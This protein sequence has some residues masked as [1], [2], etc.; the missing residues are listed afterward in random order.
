MDFDMMLVKPLTNLTNKIGLQRRKFEQNQS[1][2]NAILI[3]EPNND[4]ILS[5]IHTF[6]TQAIP[7]SEE[8]GIN[9]PGL[10]TG[11]I[12]KHYRG[13]E[14]NIPNP[15]YTPL[16]STGV[17]LPCPVQVMPRP[18]FYPIL[19]SGHAVDFLMNTNNVSTTHTQSRS[20]ADKRTRVIP[21]SNTLILSNNT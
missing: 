2:N 18:V 4:F 9:G 1:I 13:C 17:F 3:F 19:Y 11:V 20:N 16:G 15:T 5:T 10:V 8:F 21:F 6:L 14:K 12:K 7:N